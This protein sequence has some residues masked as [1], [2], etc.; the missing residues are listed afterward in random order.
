MFDYI[1]EKWYW[2]METKVWWPLNKIV[3]D[4]AL[5]LAPTL[6]TGLAPSLLNS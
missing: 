6:A 3:L 4:L 5:G 1:L 2:H